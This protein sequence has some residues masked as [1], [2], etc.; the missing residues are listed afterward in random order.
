LHIYFFFLTGL[1]KA[2]SSAVVGGAVV[3]GV[4]VFFSVILAL[5]FIFCLKNNNVDSNANGRRPHTNQRQHKQNRHQQQNRQ[6]KHVQTV[7]HEVVVIPGKNRSNQQGQP[8]V[9][10]KQ[11][12]SLPAYNDGLSNSMNNGYGKQIP[13]SPNTSSMN[14]LHQS[15]GS[16][17]HQV[18]IHSNIQQ[19]SYNRH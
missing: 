16:M 2:S 9:Y 5:V 15:N 4:S 12:R 1:V 14:Y 10:D 19:N 13:Q 3:L 11:M 7:P 8:N 6:I 17:N 18:P